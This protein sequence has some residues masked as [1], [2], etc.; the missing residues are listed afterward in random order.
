MDPTGLLVW[1]N[2]EPLLEVKIGK[3]ELNLKGREEGM[4][5][6]HQ[7]RWA[8]VGTLVKEHGGLAEM[9]SKLSSAEDNRRD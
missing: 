7:Q 8:W 1:A 3:P 5:D 4:G 2:L 9:D 6:F